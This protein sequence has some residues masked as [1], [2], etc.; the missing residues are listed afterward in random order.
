M[1]AFSKNSG[2]IVTFALPFITTFVCFA[3]ELITTGPAFAVSTAPFPTLTLALL[4]RRF[5]LNEPAA[6][7]E[8]SAAVPTA[9][10]A[11]KFAYFSGV[12]NMRT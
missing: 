11:A 3:S 2:F 6:V 1:T 7:I 4:S 5:R 12:K 10:D 8:P 9:L